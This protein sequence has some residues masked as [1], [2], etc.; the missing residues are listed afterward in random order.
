MSKKKNLEKWRL[1]AELHALTRKKFP[2]R[3]IIIYEYDDLW[4]ADVFEMHTIQQGV[5]LHS[6][7][8][9]RAE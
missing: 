6:H 1:M 4:Q 9:R 7:Y 5:L 3:H 2:R 8:Y